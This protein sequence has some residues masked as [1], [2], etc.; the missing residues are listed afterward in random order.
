VENQAVLGL[1]HY[2]TELTILLFQELFRDARTVRRGDS[3]LV[4]SVVV[5]RMPLLVK[6]SAAACRRAQRN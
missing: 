6:K 1:E 3:D 5:G 4:P 2:F